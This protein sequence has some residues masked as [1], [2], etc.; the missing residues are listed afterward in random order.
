[1][2]EVKTSASCE[3]TCLTGEAWQFKF[4]GNKVSVGRLA[5]SSPPPTPLGDIKVLSRRQQ[6]D[7]ALLKSFL[8]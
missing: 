5:Y 7:E 4:S 1:M 8:F 2:L 3:T 6:K